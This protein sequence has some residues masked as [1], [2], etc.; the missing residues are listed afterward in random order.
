MYDYRAK[1][2][3]YDPAA[4]VPLMVINQFNFGTCNSVADFNDY[5]ILANILESNVKINISEISNSGTRY[6]GNILQYTR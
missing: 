5:E 3:R 1:V 4:M 2:V 6:Y